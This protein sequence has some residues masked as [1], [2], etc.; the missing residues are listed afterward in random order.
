MRFS[1]DRQNTCLQDSHRPTNLIQGF[2]N[3]Y[4]S[5]ACATAFIAATTLAGCKSKTAT[6]ASHDAS[7]APSAPTSTSAAPVAGPVDP[8]Q[9]GTIT[10]VVHLKGTPPARVTI[11]MSMDPAC[12]L[13]GDN[14][15]EQ[16]IVTKGGLGNVFVY[17]KA[18]LPASS[19]PPGAPPV[20]ID[21]H[22]CRF[23][24]HVAAVQQG[25]S[26]T[27]TN[28][29]PTMHNVHTVTVG[30]NPGLDVSQ[31][32]GAAPQTRQFN[33]PDTMLAIRCNNHPWMQAF[34]NVAPNPYFAVTNP[35]GT[36]TLKGLPAGTYTLAA[37][38][39]KLGEQDT[40]I[41]VA[42]QKTTTKDVTFQMQ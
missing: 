35:D 7:A 26:I 24:P 21:Q 11:D 28:S 25:G 2:V 41:T 38:H 40:Q 14:L 18:G 37:V 5:I 20:H 29:D 42:P 1:I 16:Y 6:P 34:L 17:I 31:G 36:F 8:S 39:E 19:A 13:A 33:A 15:T 4:R 3:S 12:S 22:G 32:P 23:V 30:G 27:F 9:A 10:G